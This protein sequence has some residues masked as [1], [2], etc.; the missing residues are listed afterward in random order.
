MRSARYI[1]MIPLSILPATLGGGCPGDESAQ[2]EDDS[3]KNDV[4]SRRHAMHR[5]L[6]GSLLVL[7]AACAADRSDDPLASDG[8]ADSAGIVEGSP[9][10]IAVLKLVNESSR[11]KLETE[12]LISTTAVDNILA[13]R[14]GDDGASGT[15]DD[16]QFRTLA[17]L[18]AVP[19]V[20]PGVFT[21]LLSYASSHGLIQDD[22]FDLEHGPLMSLATF[23]EFIPGGD[24][25]APVGTAAFVGRTR[26]CDGANCTWSITAAS[27]Y[28]CLSRLSPGLVPCPTAASA[29]AFAVPHV[30]FGLTFSWETADQEKVRIE[31][32]H[33][34]PHSEVPLDNCF[35]VDG[36]GAVQSVLGLHGFVYAD[37]T[38]N[39]VT[40]NVAGGQQHAVTGKLTE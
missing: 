23:L 34:G 9:E 15:P 20:G 16:V 29:V 40:T 7:A 32:T 31:C 5:L 36:S 3:G 14:N 13:V 24:G 11:D 21:K 12:I 25:Q 30:R 10:A 1:R 18:D 6:L 2:E 37:G 17:E 35:G 38:Y 4:S 39:L 19:L 22:P 28:E 33:E 27:N 8:K 26:K